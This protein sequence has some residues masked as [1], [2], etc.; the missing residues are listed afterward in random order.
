MQSTI[1]YLRDLTHELSARE[2]HRLDF[3]QF[4]ESL[5][6][7][8]CVIDEDTSIQYVN[9]NVK[10]LFGDDPKVP[11]QLVET[12]ISDAF[13]GSS[14]VSGTLKISLCDGKAVDAV[15]WSTPIWNEN[16]VTHALVAFCTHLLSGNVRDVER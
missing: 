13:N 12:Q 2:S 14:S 6:F 8:V 7:G 16:S 4:V 1:D 5:P 10:R 9:Q 3:E 15:V 11:F